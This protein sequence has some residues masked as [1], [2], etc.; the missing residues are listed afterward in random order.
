MLSFNRRIN[1]K[2]YYIRMAV[3]TLLIVALATI[4]DWLFGEDESM[5]GGIATI[6]FLLSIA[7]WLVFII[8]QIRQRANDIGAHPLFITTIA[9][10][11]PLFLVLGFI[12]GQKQINK[13]G[14]VP[15]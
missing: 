12:P 1:G 10:W 15:N 3:S 13:Y 9:W 14:P 4:L 6:I 8:S 11:T 7:F 2:T 5:V